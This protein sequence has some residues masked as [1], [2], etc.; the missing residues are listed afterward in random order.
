MTVSPQTSSFLQQQP[1]VCS[2]S[3]LLAAKALMFS[4]LLRDDDLPTHFVLDNG[5]TR[6]YVCNLS[7][8]TNINRC[9]GGLQSAN[10]QK[11]SATYIGTIGLLPTVM[12]S[13]DMAFNLLSQRDL[14]KGNLSFFFKNGVCSVYKGD[15]SAPIMQIHVSQDDHY[16]LSFEDAEWLCSQIDY[17]HL[18]TSLIAVDTICIADAKPADVSI[19][20]HSR[21]CHWNLN[22]IYKAVKDGHLLGLDKHMNALRHDNFCRFCAMSKG[23]KHSFQGHHSHDNYSFGEFLYSDVCG[24]FRVRTRSGYRYFVTYICGKT[25]WAWIFLLKHKSEQ[26]EA[27]H[28]LRTNIIPMYGAQVKVLFSDNGGE[29]TSTEFL[30]YCHS[31]GVQTLHSAPR[32]PEQNGI[33]ERFNR[34]VVEALR[35][36]LVTSRMARSFWGE[37]VLSIVFVRNHLPHSSLPDS[38]SPMEAAFN[39]IPNVSRFRALGCD[40]YA[41]LDT[42]GLDKLLIKAQPSTLLGYSE[43]SKAYRVLV[44]ATK[45]IAETRNVIFDEQSIVHGAISGIANPFVS[46]EPE[47]VGAIDRLVDPRLQILAGGDDESESEDDEPSRPRIQFNPIKAPRQELDDD[48]ASGSVP[49][50]PIRVSHPVNR[51]NYSKLGGII[52]ELEEAG[53]V[54]HYGSIEDVSFQTMNI[55]LEDMCLSAMENALA[56]FDETL[57]NDL[58]TTFQEA[59]RSPE[60][61]QWKE[62]MDYEVATLNSRNLW[63]EVPNTGQF[64]HDTKWV[65]KR[66]YADDLPIKWRSRLVLRG[67]RQKI[68]EDYFETFSPVLRKESLRL[69]FALV[70][71]LDLECHQVDVDSAFPYADLEEEIYI[72]PPP[73]V[74]VRPGMVLRLWKALYGLKQAPRAW[75]KLVVE[76]LSEIGFVK[77]QTDHCLFTL[78]KSDGSVVIMAVYVDDIL[79]AANNIEA[80]LEVKE[81][82]KEK[83]AIKDLGPVKHVLGIHVNHNILD[84]HLTLDQSKMTQ[85]IVTEFDKYNVP[86]VNSARGKSLGLK[87]IEALPMTPGLVLGSTSS[88]PEDEVGS[89]EYVDVSKLPYMRLVGCV[90]Y[91]MT[92]TRPDISLATTSVSRFMQKPLYVHWLACLHLV[93]YLKG[94]TDYGIS[95]SRS[96]WMNHLLCAFSDS[97]WGTSDTA[98]RR[99]MTG[100]S[101]FLSGGPIAWRSCL[102]T[103]VAKSA[104]EAE[105][106]ALSGTTDEVVFI[107]NLLS[108]LGFVQEGPTPIFEDNKGAVDLSGNPMYHKRTKHIDIRYHSIREMVANGFILVLKVPTKANLADLHTKPVAK[109]VFETLMPFLMSR[110]V[111]A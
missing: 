26:H 47:Y 32:S 56:V 27:F 61:E 8:L 23:T 67:F 101:V 6:T 107:R 14:E 29:Y 93:R 31:N 100:Y 71:W 20:I 96:N 18:L 92:C 64:C 78:R 111:S 103:T 25:R 34:T 11:S 102:Q 40:C 36:T 22:M 62:S 105:Y 68:T 77:C 94:T 53:V 1:S 51:L 2:Y 70:C 84:G 15:D 106:Y 69:F 10:G 38:M 86:L 44:W 80:V 79:I 74:Y 35:T 97:D 57:N 54:S 89:P 48:L 72:K 66:K 99:S 83:F 13:K 59:I 19:M 55:K 76:I 4:E 17:S 9:N 108:E 110:V 81:F 7:L 16:K 41:I 95:F 5:A 109:V 12:Y 3:S 52:K 28:N 73:G 45:R 39:V 43:D 88:L 42:D 91:L 37:F 21:L 90:L 85:K 49:S 50:R 24:P 87:H 75:Y 30:D 65:F 104:T 33:S 58:P 82:I 98:N 60:S 46:N 63:T